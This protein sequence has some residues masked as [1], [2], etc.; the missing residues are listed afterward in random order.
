MLWISFYAK[1]IVRGAVRSLE[2]SQW[3][4][5]LFDNKYGEGKYKRV[6]VPDMSVAGAYKAAMKVRH[7][8]EALQPRIIN[9][10]SF[11]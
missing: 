4:Q 10:N 8:S 1:D 6:V 2:K 3:T 7:I 9:S 11:Y 5:D